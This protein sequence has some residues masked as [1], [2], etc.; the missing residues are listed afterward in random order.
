MTEL[1]STQ[2]VEKQESFVGIRLTGGT[3][4]RKARLIK[5][6]EAAQQET[7]RQSDQVS[8]ARAAVVPLAVESVLTWVRQRPRA[9]VSARE[10]FAALFGQHTRR[11]V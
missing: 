5:R 9:D 2:F 6:D 7:R 3:K 4:M 8:K 1:T 11:A 10:K